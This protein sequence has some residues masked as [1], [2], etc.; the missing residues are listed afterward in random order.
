M[1]YW[2][3]YVCSS[4]LYIATDFLGCF[5]PRILFD[6]E[7]TVS[8]KRY[9]AM[10]GYYPKPGDR[11]CLIP[12]GTTYLVIG[13]VE[14]RPRDPDVQIFTATD[15]SEKPTAAR[16][17][18]VQVQPVAGA[19]GGCVATASTSVLAGGVAPGGG[20]GNNG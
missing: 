14:D 4:D 9:Q 10:S 19:G 3:S 13:T 20:L 15:T 1:S 2:S 7:A 5:N 18:R 17:I 16:T 11:V 6:G 8:Q 12:V